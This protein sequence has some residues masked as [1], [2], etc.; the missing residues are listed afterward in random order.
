MTYHYKKY[1]WTAF[2]EADLLAGGSN[3]CNFG[4]GDSFTMGSPSVKMSTYDNDSKLSGDSWY[5]RYDYAEDR[6][7][8]NGI[9]NGQAVGCKMFAEQYHVLKGS[10]GKTYYM[11]EIQI[12]GHNSEGAGNGYFTFYG[13]QPAAGVNLTVVNTCN[14]AGSWIDYSCLGAGNAAPANTAPVF[15]NVPADGVFCVDENSKLVIDLNAKDADGDTLSFSL[16]GGEDAA[17]F[18]INPDTGV[19]TFKSAPDYENPAD[20]NGDNLYKV[21]VAVDDGK[22]GVT[23]SELK[24]DVRDVEE[25][26]TCIVYEAEKMSLSCYRV[27]SASSASDGKYIALSGYSGSASQ[28]FDGV[29]GEYDMTL[30]FWDS[31]K[32]DGFIKVMVNGKVVDTIRLNAE[33]SKWVEITLDDLQLNKGDVIT[34]KGYGN[35]C[36]YAIIDNIKLCPTEPEEEPGALSGRVFVDADK[37]GID[38]AEAGVAGVTVQL[39]DATGNVVAT[40]T[41]GADG[42]YLFDDLQPGEYRVVFPTEVDG[43]V[44]T[45]QNVGGNDAIDS[46]ADV[47]TGVSDSATVVAGATTTDVDAGVKDPGTAAIEGRIFVDA[48]DNAVDDAETG[49][50]GV[51][52]RLLT[53]TGALVATTVTAADGSYQFE[54]LD[55]G[56]YVVEFP[57]S[58]NGRV[59]V[60]A[61]AGDDDTIDS[62]A[63]TSTGRTGTISLEIGELSSD[64]DAGIKDP[65]TASLGN[66]V[67]L[68]ADKDG[69]QD[70]GEVGVA[71]VTVTLFMGG[72]AIAST[73]TGAAGNYI[74]TGLKAGTYTVGFTEKAGF[75]FTAANIG[76]DALDSDADQTT[77]LTGP[78]T[79]G[80]GE[81]NLDVD[82]GLVI[83]NRAPDAMNDIAGTCAED[84]V[85]VDVLANDTDLDG[86][87]LTIV[88]VAGQ[89]I[90]EGGSVDVDG[91][92][93]ALV[94]GKLVFDGSGAYG[95]LLLGEKATVSYGYE[96][97][98][99]NGGFDTANV[100]MTF[101]GETNTLEMIKDSLPSIGSLVLTRDGALG[102]DFY[103]VTLSGTGD[104]RFDGKFFDITYCVSAY[105]PINP[106]VAVPYNMYLADA[107]S[108]PTGIVANPQNL[109]VVNWILNQD[110]QEMDN[111]DGTGQTYTE[112]EI[113][114]A[115]WGLTDDI[116][117]VSSSLGTNAN[118]QEIYDM[119]LAS[120]E[121]FVAGEGDV[122]G[123]LLDPTAAAEAAGNSQPLII[124]VE[125]DA[126]E[127]DC[128]CFA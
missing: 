34:L 92:S 97:S 35:G 9:V 101:C 42:G 58:I 47:A 64:N 78:I 63:S 7:G 56:D 120:G 74:F 51:T 14:V 29:S 52:V 50:A 70:L 90:V 89:D 49:V 99:G 48:N 102:G 66:F 114:G 76:N 2:T 75:D 41:T 93:I 12:E 77:G 1:E 82:A 116:V 83:E 10:D 112:A 122:V 37:N 31:A 95:D 25:T 22:G 19:L 111:G 84:A 88:S 96:V 46:D 107:A 60:D 39:L 55:A 26:P 125:W 119:A 108:V 73:T 30:R 123:L 126:L 54:D 100:D 18:E 124:G 6:S 28:K 53:A 104:D 98:D 72:V 44:L 105:E 106:N 117:F 32:G 86:D 3:G 110:F 33:S 20:K 8:Q 80:I 17:L 43:Q 69:V 27:G 61:N 57:K 115:I 67:F 68:D 103:G 13:A 91:V 11:I 21:I 23:Y 59:L 15:T 79:L 16:A 109:D 85:T 24:V 65:G 38:N 121:G 45:E 62:D 94:D 127:Q 81:T 128:F 4:K 71:G 113:Q 5:D 118:A 36:E 87:A 40:T